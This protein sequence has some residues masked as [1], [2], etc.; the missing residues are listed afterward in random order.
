MYKGCPCVNIED[1]FKNISDSENPKLDKVI[2]RS[3][4]ADAN[5]AG[6][7]PAVFILSGKCDD[8]PPYILL[9]I[10]FFG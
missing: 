9:P 1:I 4:S 8:S 6:I 5:I 7:T 10:C 2:G 3:K